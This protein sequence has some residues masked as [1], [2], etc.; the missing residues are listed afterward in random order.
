MYRDYNYTV[1]LSKHAVVKQKVTGISWRELV[2]VIS[3]NSLHQ[4]KAIRFHHLGSPNGQAHID[5]GT[6]LTLWK[7]VQS[8]I[9]KT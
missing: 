8:Q 3:E 6:M 5:G 4:V 2:K 1:E 9:A 7:Q